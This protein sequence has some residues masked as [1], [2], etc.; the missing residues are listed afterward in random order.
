[1]SE[2]RDGVI[3]V[4]WHGA[5]RFDVRIR[6]HAIRADQPADVGGSDTGPTPAELFVGSVAA[7]VACCAERYLRQRQL[8]AGVGVTARYAMGVCPGR[9]DAIELS[10]DAPGLP[11]G[12]RASLL[13]VLEHCAVCATL[14]VPPKV[15]FEV[16][17]GVPETAVPAA[18]RPYGGPRPGPAGSSG[19]RG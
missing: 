15:T 5:H 11:E 3:R 9:I 18:R 1:M 13:S 4:A 10:V 14:R 17:Q 12:L 19:P 2:R 7:G 16:R 8:P 6:Q